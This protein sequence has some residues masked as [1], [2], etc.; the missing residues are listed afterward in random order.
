MQNLNTRSYQFSIK[1]GQIRKG[2]WL[3]LTDRT[4]RS[5]WGDIAPLPARSQE[6][7]EEAL[8]QLEEKKAQIQQMLWTEDNCFKNLRELA[9]LPSCSFGL[10]S[11]VYDLLQPQVK[12]HLPISAFFMGDIADIL[13]QARLAEQ[14]GHRY[15]KLKVSQFSFKEAS[16]V[17][18]QLKD[19]FRL[20]I[21]VNRAWTTE[22]SLAFFASFPLDSFDYVE[23]PFQ[24]PRELNHFT[25][26]LAVDESYPACL[27]LED[28]ETLPTL[29][30]LI[31]K[32]TI[33]GGTI[34]YLPLKAWAL[35]RNISVILSS[36]FESSLGHA[37][38]A[39]MGARL[40]LTDPLGIG[41]LAFINPPFL[42]S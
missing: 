22:E 11:A 34:H 27:S 19:R 39:A 17:I 28:L 18:N 30:A 29:K 21:D 35:P 42:E 14:T 20:R 38:I 1:N 10:E 9:L 4:G 12:T 41:T 40:S 32:P 7:L 37:N 31:Y 5:G 26:P 13:E 15:A 36:S 33:Q 24:D 23:E 25:H 3:Q 2:A 16:T 6:T 8:A